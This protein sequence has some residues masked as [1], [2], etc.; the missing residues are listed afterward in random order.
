MARD[1]YDYQEQSDFSGGAWPSFDRVPANGLQGIIDGLVMPDGS[2]LQRG[3]S[4]YKSNAD[5]SG[6]VLSL[7]DG[8]LTPGRRTAFVTADTLY[9]LNTDDVSPL[10][11]SVGATF[12]VR[13]FTELGRMLLYPYSTSNDRVMVW[14]GARDGASLTISG[15]TTF[16]QGS[17]IVTNS[18][19]GFT[20]A[21]TPGCLFSAAIGSGEEMAVIASRDSASQLTLVDPWPYGGGTSTAARS[22]PVRTFDFTLGG[23]G[24]TGLLKTGTRPVVFAQIFGRL[25]VAQDNRIYPSD[26]VDD[27]TGNLINAPFFF[28]AAEEGLTL[29][30]GVIVT[31][32]EALRDLLFVFTTAGVW[33]ISGLTAADVT[34]FSGSTQ[35]QME[36]V[37]RDLVL[38]GEAGIASWH[39]AL[40]VPAV[41]DVYLFDGQGAPVPVGGGG[42]M[43]YRAYVKLGRLPGRA[44]VAQG[45]YILP[46]LAGSAWSDTL[47][48]R[49]DMAGAPF[50]R[51]R[52]HGGSARALT[53]RVDE[54]TRQPQLLTAVGKR[55]EDLTAAFDSSAS[56]DHDADGSSVDM[57]F[58]TR[59]LRVGEMLK[60]TWRRFRAQLEV[61]DPEGGFAVTGEARVDDGPFSALSSPQ[62]QQSGDEYVAS[63]NF[64]KAARAFGVQVTMS[65]SS[66]RV[67]LRS[68]RA[69]ARSSGKPRP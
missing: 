29:P 35:W 53:Q 24:G 21:I 69:G 61:Q 48:W 50:A 3:G 42:R 41:D 15:T 23:L 52:G 38:W 58:T 66:G 59:A 1:G 46:S 32:M 10:S 6:E 57:L 36:Q 9:A 17:K 34:D 33:A 39:N 60:A 62:V 22:T 68:W 51:W 30:E 65:G 47:V 55:V 28:N 27:G 67:R 19:A 54:A 64:T 26:F 4:V 13:R 25:V 31:G 40:V 49:L 44:A 12:E 63:W 43:L 8:H 7:W 5:A 20:T 37:T 56:T 16:T 18:A 2:V 45:H 11:L 14:G